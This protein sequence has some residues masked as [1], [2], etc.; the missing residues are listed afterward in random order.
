MEQN[1]LRK[2]LFIVA[3]IAFAAVSC[4]ATAESLHLLLP[5]WPLVLC[6]IVTIGF[7]IIASIGSKLVVESFN[8]HIYLEHRGLRL[9]GGIV[10][11]LIFWLVC[12]MPTNTHTFF[13]RSAIKDIVTQDLSATKSYL[14]KLHDNVKMEEEIKAEQDKLTREVNA[15]LIALSNEIDNMANPGFGD[16]AKS[17]LD[18]MATTL[19]VEKIPVLSYKGNT[20]EQRRHLKDQYRTYIYQ[21]L[22][23]RKEEIA[24][25]IRNSQEEVY[26][27]EA[28]RGIRNINRV[29]GN[30]KE[31][32]LQNRVDNQLINEADVALKDG[33]ATIKNY[34]NFINFNSEQEKELYL[35]ENQLTK[36]SRMLSVIDV[37]KDYLAGKHKGRGFVFWIVIA[38]LVDVAA[39]IFFDLAFARRDD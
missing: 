26:K 24:T 12:S 2:I 30:I 37:W 7:F 6:W 20:P 23:K 9:I 38:V 39:F 5:S 3:F 28:Q 22:D 31:M 25:T 35:A 34:H 11:V 14:Y 32:A 17:H 21:I 8:Q 27:R 15:E 10:L 33:Y 36:T 4:W 29:E 18:K 19:Q 16:R 13:Y 1:S